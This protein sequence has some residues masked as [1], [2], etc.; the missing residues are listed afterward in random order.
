MEDFKIIVLKSDV[1]EGVC[2]SH[3]PTGDDNTPTV[4]IEMW[5]K[6]NPDSPYYVSE[7]IDFVSEGQARDF[8]R[9]FDAVSAQNFLDR[10][11]TA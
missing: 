9:T 6:E 8:I 10:N 4:F 1:C 3:V 5:I 11:Y 7:S 2:L